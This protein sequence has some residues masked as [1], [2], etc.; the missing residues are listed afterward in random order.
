LV[1]HGLKE[2]RDFYKI[3]P[4]LSTYKKTELLLNAFHQG[5]VVIIDEINS[6]PMIERVLNALLEG[7]DLEGNKAKKPG[8]ML[9]GTQNPITYSGRIK[10]T[11]PL[12]HRLQTILMSTYPDNEIKKILNNKGLPPRIARDMFNEFKVRQKQN[13]NLCLRDL[14]KCAANWIKHQ[15]DDQIPAIDLEAQPQVGPMCKIVAIA[16]IEAYF[17]KKL[18]YPAIPLRKNGQKVLSIRKIAK[19]NGPLQGEVLEFGQWQKNVTDLGYEAETI[20]FNNDFTLFLNTIKQTLSKGNLPLISF[21]VNQ[22]TGQP[23]PNPNKPEA[24]EHASVI[25]AY[26][27]KTDRVSIVHWGQTYMVDIVTLFNANQALCETRQ[28]EYYQKN[29]NFSKEKKRYTPKYLADPSKK[30]MKSP[31]TPK[32]L[33][34]FKSKL[35]VVKNPELKQILNARK[36]LMVQLNHNMTDNHNYFFNNKAPKASCRDEKDTMGAL[37]KSNQIASLSDGVTV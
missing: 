20:N 26:H 5:K 9:I 14:V 8:F 25:T 16:N 18:N 29:H 1:A 23:D 3:A 36:N 13:D 33:S 21:A 31:T 35:L 4:S 24:T 10:T 34:G 30:G 2:T 32:P 11:L 19:A 17:A 7:H 28:S 12:K 27:Q 15:D 6:S 22:Q 37:N